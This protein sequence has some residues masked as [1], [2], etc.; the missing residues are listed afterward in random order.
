VLAIANRKLP[1]EH[2]AE[3]VRTLETLARTQEIFGS[4]TIAP[5]RS[6]IEGELAAFTAQTSIAGCNVLLTPAAGQDFSLVIH[7]LATNALKYGALS[8]A[9]GAVEIEGHENDDG[10]FEFVWTER[11]GPPIATPPKRVGFGQKVLREI[12]K[13]LSGQMSVNFAPEGFRYELTIPIDRITNV[14]ELAD[15]P[16]EA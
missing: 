14:S 8:T 15:I 12:A 13:G 4:R 7:E 16:R 3:F 1:R 10:R 11:R 6:I 9:T 5:L 2:S